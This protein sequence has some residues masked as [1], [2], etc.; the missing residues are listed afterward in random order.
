MLRR[1]VIVHGQG[2]STTCME[3]TGIT[4]EQR[5]ELMSQL[6][7]IIGAYDLSN[8]TF[9]DPVTGKLGVNIERDYYGISHMYENKSSMRPVFVENHTKTCDKYKYLPKCLLY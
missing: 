2:C 8:Y 6:N 4:D 1:L 5:E 7:D 3:T 9:N